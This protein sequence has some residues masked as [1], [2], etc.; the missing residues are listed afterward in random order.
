M[1]ANTSN[2]TEHEVIQTFSPQLVTAI[3]NC[4]NAVSTHCLAKGLITE[5]ADAVM[6]L[7]AMTGREIRLGS[8]HRPSGVLLK[9][10]V[11]VLRNL[12]VFE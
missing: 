7:P 11:I 3:C 2:P 9:F 8:C 6:L 4:V 10:R 5:D 12:L 1:E